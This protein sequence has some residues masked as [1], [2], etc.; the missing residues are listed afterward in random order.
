MLSAFVITLREGLE[1]SLIIGI[2]AA[3]LVKTGRTTELRKLWI[4]VL[5]AVGFSILAGVLL[6]AGTASLSRKQQE[7]VEGITGLVAV[8]VLTWMIF[9]M[10]HH[11]HHLKASLH[12]KIDEAV[13]TG[14]TFTLVFLAFT[15]VAREGLETVLFLNAALNYSDSAVRSGG[16]AILG[17]AVASGLGYGIYRGGVQLNLKA[18]FQVTGGLLIVIAAGIL[19]SSVHELNEAGYLLFLTERAWDTSGI[20]N[21]SAG[22]IAGVLGSLLKGMIGYEP[23]PTVLQVLVYWG[24][25]IPCAF[26]FFAVPAIKARRRSTGNTTDKD[27]VHASSEAT[28]LDSA[29]RKQ[30]QISEVVTG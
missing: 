9:W 8:A 13:E 23:R 21:P 4:G 10:R 29:L 24:Y 11:A 28:G 6:T 19:A 12:A 14:A 27:A 15:A 20:A 30:P 17:L 22:G 2:L 25:M 18:F 16:A 7:L 26:M 3:Y 5:A 1:A